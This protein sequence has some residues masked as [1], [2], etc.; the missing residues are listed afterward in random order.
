MQL[1]SNK[2]IEL[3]HKKIDDVEEKLEEKEKSLLEPMLRVKK[4][5]EKEILEYVKEFKRKIYGGYAQNRLIATK[6]K[7]DAFYKEDQVAD[8]DF[9]SPEPIEDL[10]RL[11]NR[12]FQKGHKYVQ[13]SEATHKE[14]YSI[15][16]NFDVACDISYVPKNIYHR[17]PFVEINGINYAH[18]SFIMIDLYRIFTDPVG[19]GTF[20][21]KKTFPRLYLLQKYY[22]F[23]RATSKLPKIP[24]TNTNKS[25]LLDVVYDYVKNR[26]SVIVF[27]K[28]AYNYFLQ[29]SGIRKDQM[30]GKKYSLLDIDSY[31]IISTNYKEDGTNLLKLLR[32]SPEYKDSVTIV[33]YYPFWQFL[34]YS[35]TIS[36]NN[37]PIV[38]IY[39]YNKR[40]LPIKRV[41][42][43][44]F[45]VSII[46]D[47]GKIN[48]AS[49]SLNLLMNI[50]LTFKARVEKNEEY[51]QFHNI[52]TSHLIEIRSYF[53][54]RNNK[55]LFDDT[56][57]Q[58]FVIDCIG[59]SV[60]IIRE[61][62]LLRYTKAK[63]KQGPIVFR[64][65]PA[66]GIKEPKS[67]YKFS[68][69]SGNPIRNASNFRI[70]PVDPALLKSAN[71]ER[72][73]GTEDE[74]EIKEE[75]EEQ[76]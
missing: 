71:R 40:C 7:A 22:P 2:D 55:N 13:A 28:Y 14:T 54:K 20:R 29:A 60:D 31:S 52:M 50:I 62:R 18:P 23:N 75:V 69:S 9:Y 66:G 41:D 53:L 38:T 73:R 34:G 56:L 47:K 12:L 11:A 19:S 49:F 21:W 36:L 30:Q 15:F 10:Y 65:D 58:E 70:V 3:F 1:Y 6:N 16:V 39:H 33:E 24:D 17:I 27:G 37:S 35:T 46:D 61:T 5:V 63:E 48:L 59:E 32:D 57:F 42:A 51:Y 64:Y 67:T 25:K 76:V 45:A 72:T 44:K 4:E 26:D 8:L 74:P 43:K 68:N